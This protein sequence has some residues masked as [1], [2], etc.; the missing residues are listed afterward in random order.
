MRRNYTRFG[1]TY[2]DI[3]TD[4][5]IRKIPAVCTDSKFLLHS[6]KVVP[7]FMNHTPRV[8]HNDMFCPG[9]PEKLSYSYTRRACARDD[10]F[11]CFDAFSGQEQ[12]IFQTGEADNRRTVLVVVEHRYVKHLPQTVFYLE[13]F[14]G[15]NI[16]YIDTA[17]HVREPCRSFHKSVRIASPCVAIGPD[18]A[19]RNRPAVHIG[20]SLEQDSLALHYRD[21]RHRPD[22]TETQNSGSVGNHCHG[23]PSGCICKYIFGIAFHSP[24]YFCNSGGI[25]ERKIDLIGKR[26]EKPESDFTAEVIFEG[27]FFC[28]F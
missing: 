14:R 21:R 23:I 27:K 20:K 19:Q 4:Q 15:G 3:S 9:I 17:V 12:V 25:C 16:L 10:Y 18:A 7:P 6:G 5:R 26:F 2:K 11:D 24:G 13:T 8:A 28:D 22:V 1:Y